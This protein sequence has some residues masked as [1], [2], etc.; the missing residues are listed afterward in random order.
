MNG[1]VANPAS[2]LVVWQAVADSTSTDHHGGG[3]AFGPDGK[4]YISTGD[5]GSP[6]TSQPLTSIT[7]RSCA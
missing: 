2:E 3:L 7:A 4:L 1:N 5:N 6:P